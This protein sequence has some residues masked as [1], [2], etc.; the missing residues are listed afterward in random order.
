MVDRGPDHSSHLLNP[1]HEYSGFFFKVHLRGFKEEKISGKGCVISWS[2]R[3]CHLPLRHAGEK[4][5]RPWGVVL[6]TTNFHLQWVL[7]V[8][9]FSTVIN[10]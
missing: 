1:I 4:V 5:K 9:L 6:I 2:E 10:V 8:R 3:S 7:S